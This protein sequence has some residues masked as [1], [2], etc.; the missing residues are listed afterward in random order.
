M[1]QYDYYNI[2]N[3]NFDADNEQIYESYK[4]LAKIYHPDLGG[5]D[6]EFKKLNRAYY[7]LS[8][9]DE[10]AKYDE[11][12]KSLY[13]AEPVKIKAK[14]IQRV[15]QEFYTKFKG[16]LK[17]IAKEHT[18]L[19]VAFSVVITLFVFIVIKSGGLPKVVNS[20]P[21]DS[22]SDK[23]LNEYDFPPDGS[24]Y[25]VGVDSSPL[26]INL[27]GTG[28]EY[29]YIKLVD[30]TGKTVQSV[31]MYPNTSTEINVPYGEYELRYACGEKW[32]GYNYLFGSKGT[33]AKCTTL[34]DFNEEYGQTVKLYPVVGGNLKS[35]YIDFSDF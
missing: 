7:V 33:Y 24:A 17:Y 26:E 9:T 22:I 4:K 15:F 5:S 27:P 30:N 35:Q 18:E 16:R 32:Y 25:E 14:H 1:Y 11:W 20:N 19:V 3:V 23:N 31:F 28:N 10:R 13:F 12:Y 29:Y 8:D 34:L 21:P 6:Y 2:L